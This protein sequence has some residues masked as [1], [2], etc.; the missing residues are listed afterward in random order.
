M[1]PV[2][3]IYKRF[4]RQIGTD[5]LSELEQEI[6]EEI[7]HGYLEN[8][9]C[10]FDEWNEDLTI[11]DGYIV[12]DL[13]SS[14]K[15]LIAD[16]MVLCWLQPK[17]NTEEILKVAVTDGDYTKKSTASML[18]KLLKLEEKMIK[19]VTRKKIKRSWKNKRLNE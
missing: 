10:E 17:I 11:E 4:L 18:D 15:S 7:M 2:Q 6:A 19:R 5:I 8:A 9:L 3:D 13:T 14:D 1:T 16:V 12:T